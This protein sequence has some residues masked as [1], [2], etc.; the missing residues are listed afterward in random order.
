MRRFA[1]TTLAL[2]SMGSL[3]SVG[4]S[5][6]QD[7]EYGDWTYSPSLDAMDDTDRSS[8]ISMSKDEEAAIGF[9]CM[10]D[11]LN[12]IYIGSYM[13]G[14]EDNEVLVRYRIDKSPA[15]GPTYWGL[16]SNNT[17][18]H[19]PMGEVAAFTEAAKAGS[20]FVIR[21]T[22]P[23]DSQILEYE[24]SLNG[25]TRALKLLSCAKGGSEVQA[26]ARDRAVRSLPFHPIPTLSRG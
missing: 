20:K 7:A 4:T 14:D 22:D 26:S 8:I 18:A 21:V 23:A 16:F 1:A 9:K 2:V 6:G 15:Q 24:F 19:I 25:L 12:F 3:A 10:S 5:T 13:I 17:A 11:G